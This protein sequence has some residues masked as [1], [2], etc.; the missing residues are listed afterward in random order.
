MKQIALILTLLHLTFASWAQCV[1]PQQAVDRFVN[2]PSMTHASVGVMFMSID[3]G[4][5]IAAANPELSV[6]TASTMK[7]VTSVAAL[8]RL[9][10]DFQFETPVYTIGKMQGD[11]LMGNIVIVGAGDPTLG[12]GFMKGINRLPDEIAQALKARGVKVVAGRIVADNDLF[13]G[14]YY[15]DWWDVGDLAQDYGAGVFPLNYRDNTIRF[16]FGINRKGRIVDARFVPDVPGVGVKDRTKPGR[17]NYLLT[18]L[19]YGDNNLVLTG[20][21]AR[22]KGKG[23]HSWIVANPCPDS[24]LV[25]DVKGAL[26]SD[27][28]MLLNHNIFSSDNDK[29]KQLLV[30]HRSPVLTE[31]VTSLLDRSDNMYT[32]ALLRA[33]AV[34]SKAYQ[35]DRADLDGN[36]VDEVKRILN[37]LGVNT[38]ALFMR[39]GSG[40][41]RVNRA[42]VHMFCNMLRAVAQKKY[43]NRRLTDLMPNAGRRIGKLIPNIQ[44]ADSLS[45]K[46][47]SMRNVQCFVGY[48]PA[49]NPTTVW[50]ILANNWGGSRATLK[51]NMD[52]MLIDVLLPQEPVEEQTEQKGQ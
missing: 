30:T 47:G 38:E 28:I 23:R 10:G 49:N 20:S 52:R 31:I 51:N 7:T 11:T 9:G 18:T 22:G 26:N 34:R 36:G 6:V 1:T 41:A 44:L 14:P 3:S 33:I 27:S 48:Y 21:A 37:N 19:D 5:V 2:D 42:S 46:S 39:D 8:E 24:L 35:D 50:A 32:H 15:S 12:T 29:E 17:R 4:K 16:N 25:A 13:V 45:L 40:L 43:N